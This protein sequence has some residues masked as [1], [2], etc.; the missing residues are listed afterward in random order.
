MGVEKTKTFSPPL[1]LFLGR[2]SVRILLIL[3]AGMVAH[4]H[5][6][7]SVFYLDDTWQVEN[8]EAVEGGQWWSDPVN[9][10]PNASYYFT[11]KFFGFSAPIF[12]LENLLLHLAVALCIYWLA[13]DFMALGGAESP[14]RWEDA[15]WLAALL[16]AVH[17]LTSEVTNYVRARDHGLV[18][19]FSLLAGGCT[20]LALQR[21]WLWA[22]G[23]LAG[24]VL[25][26]ISKGP[27]LP[28]ALFNCLAI[29]VA[30]FW[31]RGRKGLRFS[32]PVVVALG[33]SLALVSGL[34]FHHLQYLWS[35]LAVELTNRQFALHA[36]TQCRVFPQYL[37]RM[38]WPFD[39]CSDHLIAWTKDF[40]DPVAWV[41]A[42]FVLVVLGLM[43]YLCLRK[44]QP[45][46][47]LLV[48]ALAP[49]LMRWLYL[50]SELMVEY[51]T[52]PCLPFVAM[53]MAAGFHCWMRRQP[54]AAWAVACGV[55]VFFSALSFQRS[56]DWRSTD[57]LCTQISR[58]YPLHL[59]EMNERSTWDLEAGRYDAILERY[60][61][62]LET[63]NKV[64]DYNRSSP[65]RYYDNWP[66][67]VVNE[68][69]MVSE[70]IAHV[71]SKWDGQAHLD[72][73]AYRMLQNH[74]YH[75]ELWAQWHYSAGNIAL[76]EGDEKSALQHYLNA[77]SYI[78][79]PLLVDRQIAEIV[80]GYGR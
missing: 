10:L 79:T 25:A 18:T 22:L 24:V 28:Q 2:H 31:L 38:M 33:T 42:A 50:V 7:W 6:L 63:L 52:Y 47:L 70:A 30:F 62:F 76:L 43:A 55:L 49:L 1:P 53:L 45:W 27:G 66:L 8:S 40:S 68:E 39:L 12:H 9:L 34:A 36:L 17:P 59:R 69:C 37:E 20:L 23:A 29:V 41:G 61:T 35:V 54:R 5:C 11:W 13:R 75:P 19:L 46:A 80:P 74:I 32:W 67:C 21:R 77:R 51:R 64:M 57:A 78:A 26:T 58:L 4:G 48:L 71:K 44:R 16:F 15:A 73:T 56:L 3:L 65:H 60:P 14:E 72:L